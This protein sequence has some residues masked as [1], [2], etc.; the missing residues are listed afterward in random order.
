M[1]TRRGVERGF[2]RAR[3]WSGG[4]AAA[5]FTVGDKA[6]EQR[7]EPGVGGGRPR[8]RADR[9]AVLLAGLVALCAMVRR[10]GRSVS[11]SAG[12]GQLWLWHRM[13]APR[14]ETLRAVVFCD[15]LIALG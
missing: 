10:G 8:R 15:W 1:R 13:A 11:S 9:R 6:V 7:L 14:A 2:H 12:P 3:H 4:T 5:P